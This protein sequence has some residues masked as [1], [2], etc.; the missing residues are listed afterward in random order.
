M[1]VTHFSA[2][3]NGGTFEIRAEQRDGGGSIIDSYLFTSLSISDALKLF[4]V[5][6]DTGLVANSQL[7]VNTTSR[8]FTGV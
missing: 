2:T 1:I 5:M 6:R 4:Q 8:T 3:D 7:K